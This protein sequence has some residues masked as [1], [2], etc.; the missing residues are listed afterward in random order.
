[1][2]SEHPG[3]RE[4]AETCFSQCLC[5]CEPRASL[6]HNYWSQIAQGGISQGT[7]IL[8]HVHQTGIPATMSYRECTKALLHS[9]WSL[10]KCLLVHREELLIKQTLSAHL[11]SSL[12]W[13]E[14]FP[15]R[16]FLGNPPRRDM[17]RYFCTGRTNKASVPDPNLTTESLLL[18]WCWDHPHGLGKATSNTVRD[19]PA[20]LPQSRGATMVAPCLC[21]SCYHKDIQ[22]R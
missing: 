18:R 16:E 3:T 5:C 6:Q 21:M 13:W 10:A 22:P 2:F 15:G 14:M 19:S 11:I 4:L 20:M 9:H 1:M 7:R 17:E 12:T 8:V